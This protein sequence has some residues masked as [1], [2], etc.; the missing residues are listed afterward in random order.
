[1]MI[2]EHGIQTFEV[3]VVVLFLL[4]ML[5]D[6]FILTFPVIFEQVV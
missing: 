3:M 2:D 6:V 1:M 4:L 5:F